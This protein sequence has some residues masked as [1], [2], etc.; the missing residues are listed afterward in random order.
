MQ[1]GMHRGVALGGATLRADAALTGVSQFA[2]EVVA[3]LVARDPGEDTGPREDVLQY[4]YTEALRGGLRVLRYAE[5][6][7]IIAATGEGG[8]TLLVHIRPA[9]NGLTGVLLIYHAP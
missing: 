1:H 2:A 3:R 9:A 7:D 4:H 8:E 5:P 6:E